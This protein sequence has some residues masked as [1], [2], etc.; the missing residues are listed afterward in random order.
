MLTP[1]V[2]RRG[3]GRWAGVRAHPLTRGEALHTCFSLVLALSK[4]EHGRAKAWLSSWQGKSH[5]PKKNEGEGQYRRLTQQVN[6]RA[7]LAGVWFTSGVY[8]APWGQG[9][10]LVSAAAVF[11]ACACALMCLFEWMKNILLALIPLL[12]REKSQIEIKRDWLFE[13]PRM[14]KNVHVKGCIP[15]RHCPVLPKVGTDAQETVTELPQSTLQWLSL[16]KV[17]WQLHFLPLPLKEPNAT[18]PIVWLFLH[19]TSTAW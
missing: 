5:L 15:S 8:G 19:A 4:L 12:V 13:L 1:P 11:S 18:G 17:P 7:G 2:R 9:P 10:G 14:G 6:F 16:G 3:K